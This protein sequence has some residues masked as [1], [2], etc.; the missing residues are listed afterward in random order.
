MTNAQHESP[1]SFLYPVYRRHYFLI[2][3]RFL[4]PRISQ[5]VLRL[6]KFEVTSRRN[7]FVD[8]PLLLFNKIS[9]ILSQKCRASHRFFFSRSSWTRSER[10]Q[11]F[12]ITTK[13]MLNI[14]P[15]EEITQTK[16]CAWR[17]VRCVCC[18]MRSHLLHERGAVTKVDSYKY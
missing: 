10:V 17:E 11:A 8:P 3:I 7:T 12:P 4:L 16:F 18:Y 5:F 15:G 2:G 13:D 14:F 9:H 1:G 6:K